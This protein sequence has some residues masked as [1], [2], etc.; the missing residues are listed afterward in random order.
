M[1]SADIFGRAASGVRA[2]L[3]GEP[4]VM[5]TAGASANIVPARVSDN[6]SEMYAQGDSLAAAIQRAFADSKPLEDEKL[7]V[8]KEPVV[9]RLAVPSFEELGEGFLIP[10]RLNEDDRLW[11]QAIDEWRKESKEHL[12]DNPKLSCVSELQIIKIGDVTYV[13]VGGEVFSH[14]ADELRF[15]NGPWTYV[16]SF[17]NGNFGYLSDQKGYGEGGYEVT[18]AYKFYGNFNFLLGEYEKLRTQT[19]ELLLTMKDR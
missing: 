8:R 17:S 5:I 6:P 10:G 3:P 1:I 16:V 19:S 15:V 13:G 7:K 14:L 12:K 18:T 4:L 9:L 2:V 11:Q